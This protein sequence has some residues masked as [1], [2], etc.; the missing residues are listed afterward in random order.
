MEESKDP[1]RDFVKESYEEDSLAAYTSFLS[2]LSVHDS[3][4]IPQAYAE[5]QRLTK[6][7]IDNRDINYTIINDSLFREFESF[8]MV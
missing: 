3:Q 6:E 8:I 4:A 7:K 2:T 5:F 1:A